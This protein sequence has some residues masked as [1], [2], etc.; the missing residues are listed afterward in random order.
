[1]FRASLR[2][3][4]AVG[5]SA[6]P[7]AAFAQGVTSAGIHGVVRSGDGR[8]I[9]A[10]RVRVTHAGTGYTTEIEVRHGRYLI[11]GLD[12]GGPYEIAVRAVGF[13]P[14]SIKVGT[15]ALGELRPVDFSLNRVV[16][17]LE[18]AT[19]TANSDLTRRSGSNG[20]T[21]TTIGSSMLHHLPTLN[22]DFY[23][24]VRLVPQVSTRISL[25]NAGVSAGGVGFRFNNFLINGVSERTLS[26]GVSAAFAGSRSVP[27]DA[28][29]E[30][31]VLLS[32]YDASYGDFAGALVNTITKSG[33]NAF[34]GSAFV[35]ARSDRLAR[36]SASS[37]VTDYDRVQYAFSASGP[38]VRDRLHFFVSPEVQ[39]FT[40]PAPGPYAGQPSHSNRA[41]PVSDADLSRLTSVMRKYGLDAGSPGAIEN[42][43]P[44][45]NLFSR[46]DLNIPA[47]K[48]RLVL[49]NNLA[50]GDDKSFSRSRAD[51]FPLS[52]TINTRASRGSLSAFHLHTALDRA[53]GGHNELLVSLR[54]E[55]LYAVP[56][57]RQPPIRIAVPAVSGGRVTVATGTPE[58]A[59]GGS[60]ASSVTAFK[61][62]VTLPVAKAHILTV[63]A[64]VERMR[65]ERKGVAGSYGAWSFASIDDLERGV[66]DRYDLSLDFGSAAVPLTGTQT[67]AFINDKWL[68]RPRFSVTTGLRADMLAIDGRAPYQSGVDS[69]FGRRTDQMPGRRV[70]LSPRAGFIWNL[71]R[72]GEIVRGG[73]GVFSTRFPLAWIHTALMNYGSGTGL[74][75]CGRTPSDLGLPP[76][77]RPDRAS[78]PLACAN[79]ATL[80]A[81][82]RGDVDL[83][84]PDLRMMRLARASL[85]YERIFPWDIRMTG[86]L[87][88][89]RS[90]SDFAFVNLNLQDPSTHDRNGRTMYGAIAPSGV[91]I[92]AV[93]SGFS[94]VIDLRTTAHARS[95]QAAVSLEKEMSE[96]INAMLSYTWSRARDAQT[97]IRVNTR[98]T[99]TW[100]SARSYSGRQDEFRAGISSNDIP[101]R[102]VLAAAFSS[103][104]R[105]WAS[106]LALYY[107]GESGRPF[108]YVAFGTSRRG[109]LNAD[110]SNSNDPL[111][112]PR[113]ARDESEIKFDGAADAVLAQQLSFESLIS[114]TG[115]LDRQR[116]KILRRNSCREPWS[117]TTAATLKQRVPLGARAVEAQLDVFN[118]LN[119]VNSRWGHRREASSGLLEHTAQSSTQTETSQPVF[120]FDPGLPR[121]TTVPAESAFQLQLAARYR[122]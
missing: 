98:G 121:W 54:T 77:F 92:P 51:T 90:L 40:F 116:G 63:G 15:I 67:A 114:R 82:R 44:L 47:W 86:E 68:L 89:S 12:P 115:C 83:L 18:P 45:L 25:P 26:G 33:T 35:S 75:R 56:Q 8:Y 41:V 94:E 78:P 38:I 29:K 88:M 109:D 96:R 93:R 61:D 70:E 34:E 5:V 42:S 24:F 30:Y 10:A 11:Q 105:K 32:P 108:T 113:D 58:A 57:V 4:T 13:I 95:Y 69:I 49:W 50:R 76:V 103:P 72:S 74:L 118:V 16:T 104:H 101:H 7:V 37:G 65:I 110:G 39:R 66:A 64:E 48:S 62:I 46:L 111:Y 55:T 9:D 53:G 120:H 71:P 107:V 81:V 73:A 112:I 100:S 23:D 60:F 28:V 59:Q 122:F 97:P 17:E 1:M 31:Q 119:L 99:A 84:D 117:N 27:I 21:G 85:A 19:V 79:G 2:L 20:G 80:S 52:S 91:A 87:L 36:N 3:L 6:I 102:V 14:Q 106:E 43:S 22:R